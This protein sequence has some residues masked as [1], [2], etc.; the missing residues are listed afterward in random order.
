M[1]ESLQ[2]K[3][4]KTVTTKKGRTV[5]L[6]FVRWEDLDQMTE[7]I[8]ELSKE[9]TFITFSGETILKEGEAKYLADVLTQMEFGNKVVIAA[10]EGD[11]QVGISDVTR[12]VSSRERKKH[13][14]V[15]G[16]SIRKDFRGEGLGHEL[17]K[18][19]IEQAK[20]YMDGLRIIYLEVYGKNDIAQSLYKKL[21][22]IECGRM[23]GGLQYRGEYIDDITMYLPL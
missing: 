13:L 17:M 23:P 14:G 16:L 15:L 20:T 12:V 8:N 18:T 3:H 6:R 7:Y 19:V 2:G 21:G 10:F 22:F 9:D 1:K 4:I 5:E 11:R